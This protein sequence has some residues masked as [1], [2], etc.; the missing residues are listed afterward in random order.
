MKKSKLFIGVMSGTSL[1]GVDVALC[2]I[3]PKECKLLHFKEYSYDAQLKADVLHAINNGVSLKSFGELHQRLG[4]LFAQKIN[5]FLTTLGVQAESICAIG[6]HGQTL[7]HEPKSDFPFSLQLGCPNRV[8]SLTK[9][10]TVTDFRNMDIANGGEGAPFAPAFHHFLFHDL[11]GKVAILNIGGMANLTLLEEPLRGW[12]TGCG[13]VLLDYW[14]ELS[15]NKSYDKEG[16]FAKSG[17]IITELL[18][19]MLADPYFTQKA[20][21]STGRE[22]FNT[23]FLASYLPLYHTYKDEDIQRTLLELTAQSIANDANSAHIDTLI[24]CGG[25]AKNIFLLQRLQ[26]LIHAKVK[27]SQ[28]FGIDADALEAMAFAWFAYKNIRREAVDL[29]SVT[30]AKKASILGGVYG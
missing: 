7:W 6:L 28:E 18:A 13:N 15:Q 26:K 29:C 14:I 19:S 4:L 11:E 2:E 12:D 8:A 10:Q 27:L 17:E 16:T 24:L 22:Y 30:G 25:G 20:P 5:I 9:I 3:T 21:K 1:D 23:N